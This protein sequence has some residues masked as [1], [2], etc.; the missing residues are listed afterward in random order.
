[1]AEPLELPAGPVFDPKLEPE[2]D[3]PNLEQHKSEAY[4]EQDVEAID[5]PPNKAHD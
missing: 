3:V 4:H 1:M 2:E 5:K